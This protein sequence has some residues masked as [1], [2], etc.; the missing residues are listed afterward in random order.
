MLRTD[1]GHWER[2]HSSLTTN[3]CLDG[4]DGLDHNEVYVRKI[5]ILYNLKTCFNSL[6]KEENKDMNIDI[7]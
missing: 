4:L 5:S 7:K 3:R 2:I 6:I 1:D